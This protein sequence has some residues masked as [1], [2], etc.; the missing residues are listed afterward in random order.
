MSSNANMVR[1]I[2]QYIEDAAEQYNIR[3]DGMIISYDLTLVS[4]SVVVRS[5]YSVQA[6]I[7]PRPDTYNLVAPTKIDTCNAA[8]RWLLQGV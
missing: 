7:G 1:L 5:P 8:I 4:R 2:T 6:K 3:R